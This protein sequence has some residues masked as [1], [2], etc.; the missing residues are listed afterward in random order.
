MKPLL[1]AAMMLLPMAQCSTPPAAPAAVVHA[2]PQY[3]DL[4]QKYA[5]PAGWDVKKMSYFM[6][7]ESR[8]HMTSFNGH[9]S[10]LLQINRVNY[11]YLQSHLKMSMSPKVLFIPKVN[12]QAAALLCKYWQDGLKFKD[13]CYI[14]WAPQPVKAHNPIQLKPLPGLQ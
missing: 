3:E 7:R 12:V 2:C 10:G 4:L 13:A 6:W 1:S 8:C 14:P 5:P 9:D 11:P